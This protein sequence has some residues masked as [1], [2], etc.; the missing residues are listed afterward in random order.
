MGEIDPNVTGIK[1]SINGVTAPNGRQG[2]LEEFQKESSRINSARDTL[3][4]ME[5]K[6]IGKTEIGK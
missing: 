4:K 6:G 2:G 3:K 5:I 1:L